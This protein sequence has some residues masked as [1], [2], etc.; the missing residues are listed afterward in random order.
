MKYKIGDK[1]KIKT[2]EEM[3]KEYGK[4]GKN[5]NCAYTFVKEMEED[6]EKINTNRIVTIKEI[7]ENEFYYM[8]ELP[9]W[10]WSDD[11]IKCLAK[12]YKKPELITNRW[13]I[14]DIR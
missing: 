8:K 13:E 12:N 6:L 1:V 7:I 9:R 10:S 5:I 14:L 3:E 2:W 4:R 11:I